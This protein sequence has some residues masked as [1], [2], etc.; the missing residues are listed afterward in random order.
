MALN[1]WGMPRKFGS[2]YKEERMAQIADELSK[3][4]YDIYLFEELWMQPD[5]TTVAAKGG[6]INK[7][8]FWIFF[9][10]SSYLMLSYA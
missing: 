3:A 5:H 6:N 8:L 10:A 4:H 1:T 9:L 2:E 7:I